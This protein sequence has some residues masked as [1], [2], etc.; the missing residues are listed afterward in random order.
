MIM[1]MWIDR[2]AR[3]FIKDHFFYVV[4]LRVHKDTEILSYRL[5]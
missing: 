5:T 2:R 1:I 4:K 3:Q